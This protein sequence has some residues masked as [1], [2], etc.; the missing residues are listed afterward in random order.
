[1]SIAF[2]PSSVTQFFQ[3]L[4]DSQH[5]RFSFFLM[6]V[7]AVAIIAVRPVVPVQKNTAARATFAHALVGFPPAVRATVPNVFM[8]K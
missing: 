6:A 3:R 2:R 7:F 1:M 5:F 8:V 4:L